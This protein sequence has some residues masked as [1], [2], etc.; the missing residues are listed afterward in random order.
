[1]DEPIL[2]HKLNKKVRSEKKIDHF[3]P[4]TKH[5]ISVTV[6]LL[7]LKS[8][9][10]KTEKRRCIFVSSLVSCRQLAIHVRH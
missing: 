4:Q 9:A 2:F 5:T 3:I 1:M 7:L 10:T 6:V 8:L